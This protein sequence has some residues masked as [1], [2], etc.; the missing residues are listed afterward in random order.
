[1]AELV[2]VLISGSDES[3]AKNIYERSREK[4]GVRESGGGVRYGN[5][6]QRRMV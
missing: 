2:T 5:S 1:M 4:V 3:N 6:P